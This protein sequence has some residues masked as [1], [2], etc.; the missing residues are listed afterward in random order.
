MAK[1][2]NG[3]NKFG[4]LITALT[5]AVGGVEASALEMTAHAPK[6]ACA[7]PHDNQVGLSVLAAAIAS[8]A[9]RCFEVEDEFNAFFLGIVKD[10]EVHG[11]HDTPEGGASL[12]K[13]SIEN[14]R[15]IE[16][17]LKSL[18]SK[19]KHSTIDA[20]EELLAVRKSIARVRGKMEWLYSQMLEAEGLTDSYHSD[21][22]LNDLSSL[23]SEQTENIIHRIH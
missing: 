6:Y 12:Y 19:F 21:V 14:A 10:V 9:K 2:A 18:S 8:S 3:S 17:R 7:S 4:S 5:M 1:Q 20:P 16:A 23:A 22:N 13:Q 11:I 15:D